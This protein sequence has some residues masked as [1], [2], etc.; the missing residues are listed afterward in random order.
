M[1]RRII[2]IVAVLGL[3]VIAAAMPAFSKEKPKEGVVVDLNTQTCRTLL[4]MTGDERDFTV[5]FYQGFISGMKN[6]TLF[7]GP[8]L[9]K[10]TDQVIDYCIDHPDD[11]LLKVFEAKRTQESKGAT[12]SEDK[13]VAEVKE[14]IQRHDKALSQQD[15]E[16]V[17]ATY[18]PTGEIVLMGTGPGEI[19]VGKEQIQSA[20]EHFFADFD[21]GTFVSDCGWK[22][23]D[24]Q[25]D[26]GWIMA[27]CKCTDSKDGKTREYG[28]NV[29]GTLQ[30]IDGKWYFRAMHFSNLTGP[31][32]Q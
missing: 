4:R 23:G 5:I 15:L 18:A 31:P 24:V 2:S 9:S 25:D 16:V 20:Y 10:D 29:S 27:V 7:N 30:K 11:A 13:T 28:L 21:K 3:F 6:E 19:W 26:M 22:S 8:E 17:L 12:K 1:H 32:P 14:M